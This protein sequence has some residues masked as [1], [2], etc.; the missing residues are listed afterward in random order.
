MRD[1]LSIFSRNVL[2]PIVITILVLSSMLLIL[3]EVSDAL[4]VSV[5]IVVN[6]SIGIIQEIRA[7]MMLRKLEI[8]NRPSARLE[9]ADGSI[10]E[11]SFESIKAGDKILL[12][13]G[14]EVP[15][16]A[17]VI[18]SASLEVDES[19]M[20][21]ES[22]PV[23]KRVGDE[24]FAATAVVAG[25]AKI[26]VTKAGKDTMASQ[27]TAKLR[28][29]VPEMT[30][31]Q[32]QISRAITFSTF[33][34]LGLALMIFIIYSLNGYN[35]VQIVK[36]ITSG[37]VTVV[38]E[39]LLL[40]SSLLL[41]YG[42]IRLS[43]AKVL[44]QKLSSI[45]ALALLNV[46]CVDKTGTLTGDEVSFESLEPLG[47]HQDYLQELVAIN[48]LA[49]SGGNAT[50][51][52]IID[53]LKVNIKYDLI[54][55]VA[56]SSRRKLSAVRVKINKREYS[57]VLGAPE[58]VARIAPLDDHTEAHIQQL[59]AQGKRL[60][61]AAVVGGEID[62][63]RLHHGT[64]RAV[65]LVVLGN[66]LRDGVRQT[67][68]F[69]QKQ[70][71]GIKVISGDNPNTVRYI[72]QSAGIVGSENVI[73]GAELEAFD[74]KELPKIV[75][76]Y[77]IF[78]RVA[79]EQK[80]K[81]IDAIQSSGKFVGMIGDGVNDALAIKKSDL[82]VAMYS[83][84]VSTRRVADIVLLNNSFNS[85]PAGMRL[86]NRILQTIEMIAALFFHKIIFGLILLFSTIFVGLVYPLSPR[87]VTYINM[88]LVTIPTILWTIFT[89]MPKR[90]INP[91][92]FWQDTLLAVVPIALLSGFLVTASYLILAQSHSDDLS[93]VSTT[94]SIIAATVGVYFVFL[95]PRM[96]DLKNTVRSRIALA[97]YA[98]VIVVISLPTIMS[99]F[100]RDFFN[101]TQP[102]WGDSWLLAG[103]VI[104][105]MY[106]QWLVVERTAKRIRNRK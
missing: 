39:G 17:E 18:E 47:S 82:G 57:L 79:P 35:A 14:D 99:S 32:R 68:A 48:V 6:T 46:L 100:L 66:S 106:A 86:G 7:R 54:E 104:A 52:A 96:F 45:E 5:V 73:T 65:G 40:G 60:L 103:L 3:G 80:E 89:P 92:R 98:L 21:G 64:G 63:R 1:W 4:F 67:V 42:S 94:V 62:L 19:I 28:R 26:L 37:A 51:N 20:T 10:S 59:A 61:L 72:A 13:L 93:G 83:G 53:N 8:L 25:T 58:F 75:D 49:T 23:E 78:A 2:S 70:G 16:D 88:F 71:V 76:K 36:T 29:Y 101:F 102:A 43:G 91:K 38:P 55:T 34:A 15:A 56:F 11:E 69:M 41:A 85:M 77:V 12:R 84:A 50:G 105:V 9:H 74:D 24:V 81:L 90:R 87:H 30:P 33:G 97:V 31:I 44:A 95:L 22:M 27:M